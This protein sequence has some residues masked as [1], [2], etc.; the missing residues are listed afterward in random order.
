MQ[1]GPT[2]SGS[3]TMVELRGLAKSYPSPTGPVTVLD[4]ISCSAGRG[5]AVVL[6]GVSGSGKSTLLNVLG[7][8]DGF[9]SG[10][11]TVC[12]QDLGGLPVS[13]RAGFRAENIGFVFQ[14]FNLL[15]MLNVVENVG[16][17]LTAL[18]VSRRERRE[19]SIAMLDA[20][21]IGEHVEKF[22]DQLSGGEQ[23]RVAIARAPV[24][25][26][27]LLLADE[28]TGALDEGTA[29]QV[30]DLMCALQRSFG[31]TLIMATHDALVARHAS[32]EWRLTSGH[33]EVVGA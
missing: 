30:M 1:H 26:P 17:S 19:R 6:R 24:K 2:D 11:V 7:A 12:G 23:Q 22:P 16:V 28:P 4:G 9:D 32:V 14:Y 25:R 10:S 29:E 8:L 3:E 33:V 21:G 18:G 13:R 27:R 31:T 15:P 20:V 5:Q